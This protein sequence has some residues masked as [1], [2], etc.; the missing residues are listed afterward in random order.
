MSET[1]TKPAK[2][3]ETKGEAFIRLASARVPKAAD[4]LRLVGQL[5]SANYETNQ[6]AIK[7][8]QEFLQGAMDEAMKAL[9]AKAKVGPNAPDYGGEEWKLVD[10]AMTALREGD[11]DVA[12]AKLMKAFSH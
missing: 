4:A 10:E 1:E 7:E 12:M 6:D 3:N 5:G 2:K 11:S 8:I 9:G